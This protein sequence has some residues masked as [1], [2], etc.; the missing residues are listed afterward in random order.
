M[1]HA[2]VT[3]LTALTSGLLLAAAAPAAAAGKAQVQFIEPQ[4]FAD[5]GRT[6]YDRDQALKSLGDYIQSLGARL[7]DGQTLSVDVTN[8]DLAGEL[9]PWRGGYEVRVLRGGADWPQLS[10][11]WSLQAGGRTLKSGEDRLSDPNYLFALRGV[12]HQAGDLVFEK[13]MLRLWFETTFGRPSPTT[14]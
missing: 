13:R 10:L 7:P 4:Q 11:R 3:V 2:A 8:V 5:A 14:P 9:R 12:D 1:H 6:G